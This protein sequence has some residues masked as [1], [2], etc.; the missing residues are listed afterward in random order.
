MAELPEVREVVHIDEI[1]A[2]VNSRGVRARQVLNIAPFRI[3]NLVLDQGQVI[4]PHT[5]PVE[6]F[7]YVIQGAG[8]ITIGG[9]VHAVKERDIL[10]CPKDTVM[11]VLAG[12][13]GLSILNVKAPN[14]ATLA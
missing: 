13:P 6:V 2:S 8:E 7:F 5:S 12:A 14:P 3:M 1:P 9:Q 11:S 4:P 10:P